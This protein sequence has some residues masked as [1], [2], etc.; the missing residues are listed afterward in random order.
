MEFWVRSQ[1][2]TKFVKVEGVYYEAFE[3]DLDGYG[4][5]DTSHEIWYSKKNE[6]Y[7][8]GVYNSKERCLEIIDEIQWLLANNGSTEDRISA[9]VSGIQ[10]NFIVYEMPKE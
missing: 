6:D 4:S 2:K 5:Y 10:N 9:K 8:I 7:S 3:T 1:D